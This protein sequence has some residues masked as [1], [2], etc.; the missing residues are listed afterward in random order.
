MND[1]SNLVGANIYFAGA[2]NRNNFIGAYKQDCNI[3][4]D[5]IVRIMNDSMEGCEPNK[6]NTFSSGGIS[7]HMVLDDEHVGLVY[8]LLTRDSY[9]FRCAFAALEELK[10]EAIDA[11][12]KKS[13]IV[14]LDKVC[15]RIGK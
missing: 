5:N 4:L 11:F 10:K 2:V 15:R 6:I 7:W 3:D 13:K 8:I 1:T 9:P 14:S 12:A